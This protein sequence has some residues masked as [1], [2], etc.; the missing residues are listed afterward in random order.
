MIARL[1]INYWIAPS[2]LFELSF[3]ISTDYLIK[4]KWKTE[5]SFSLFDENVR[6]RK[7]ENVIM[8]QVKRI[9]NADLCRYEW[10]YRHR[11][12][13]LRRYMIR[14]VAGSTAVNAINSQLTL[15]WERKKPLECADWGCEQMKM[16]KRKTRIVQSAFAPLHVLFQ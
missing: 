9:R 6:L 4:L 8:W 10:V 15:K 5:N 1:L 7:I 3:A 2:I 14:L 12:F 16:R 11:H 13:V